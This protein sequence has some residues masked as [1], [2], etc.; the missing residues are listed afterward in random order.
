MSQ[1]LVSVCIPV[2]NGEKY[3]EETIRSVL[4]QDFVNIEVVIQENASSDRTREIV[5][6]M[7]AKDSRVKVFINS[8]TV[9]MAKNWNLALNNS[10]GNY[11]QLL[12]AD[13]LIMPEFVS[14]ALSVLENNES[15]DFVSTEHLL[16]FPNKARGR[17]IDVK[18]GERVL[19]CGEVLLKNPFSINFTVFRKAF[20]VSLMLQQGK[21]FREPYFTCDYDLWIRAA[22][23]K[24]KVFFIPAVLAKYRVHDDSLSS[25]KIKMIRHTLLVLSSNKKFLSSQCDLILKLT[26]IR[27]FIRLVPLMFKNKGRVLRLIPYIIKKAV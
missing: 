18:G 4:N 12:S 11:V 23:R 3:I 21:Y 9:S 10:N 1:P 20:L 15:I 5:Q 24:S 25:K 16:L 14:S 2:Y 27:F 19:T 26:Y 22:E 6:N 17:K 13:D 7:A 8:N